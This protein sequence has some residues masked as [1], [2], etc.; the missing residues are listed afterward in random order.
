MIISA[1]T[2][3]GGLITKGIDAYNNYRRNEALT[4]AMDT[5]IENDRKFH[6]R[7]LTLEDNLGV[8]TQMVATGFAQINDSFQTL[9]RSIERTSYQL[10]SMMNLTEQRFRETHEAFA[11]SHLRCSHSYTH[12]AHLG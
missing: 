10:Q 5:L 9:N 12:L 8:V 11:P 2:G 4:K 3:I 6:Q 1:I 7:M